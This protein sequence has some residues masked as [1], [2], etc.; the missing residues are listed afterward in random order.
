MHDVL[1]AHTSLSAAQ[2]QRIT[3]IE[4]H[5]TLRFVNV[6]HLIGWPTWMSRDNPKHAIYF[7]DRICGDF[8]ANYVHAQ[9]F[10]TYTMFLMP[11][12]QDYR[13]F[14]NIDT[15]ALQMFLYGFCLFVC[16]FICLFV[17]LFLYVCLF[18]HHSFNILFKMF[19]NSY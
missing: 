8:D 15:G 5:A 14:I 6:S 9:R 18:V 3:E 17:C 4:S 11:E 7:M 13:Y 2:Q 12:L 10:Y 1:I 19:S 16:L